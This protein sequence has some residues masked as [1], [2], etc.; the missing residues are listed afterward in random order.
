[1]LTRAFYAQHDTKTPVIV[2]AIAMG[3]NVVFSFAFSSLFVRIGWMPH[4]GLALA[5]S[6]ATALEV[7]ALFI[8]MRHRLNGIND[9]YILRGGLQTIGGTLVMSVAV[10]LCLRLFSDRSAWLLSIGGIVAGG[11]VYV[12]M[13]MALRVP[14]L[15]ILMGAVQSR[16]RGNKGS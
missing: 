16:L 9:F 13:M 8:I 7:T 2:G 14:E 5:N 4:G 11:S 12:M 15:A 6:L 10:I 3:L 1:M